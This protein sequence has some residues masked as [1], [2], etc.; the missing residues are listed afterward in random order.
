MRFALRQL[1]K[2][3]SFT[4]IAVLTLA[5]GIGACVSIFSVANAMLLRHQ[6]YQDPGRLVWVW[7][8]NLPDSGSWLAVSAPNFVDWQ[9]QASAFEQL[10]AFYQR[11]PD[12]ERTE[13]DAAPAERVGVGRVTVNLLSMLGVKPLMGR[14]FL[15]EDEKNQVVVLSHALWQRRFN[16]DPNMLDRTVRLNG[17]D[18][19]VIGIMP[20]EFHFPPEP[21]PDVLWVPLAL[22]GE[23]LAEA[24]RGLRDWCVLGRLRPGA[25][26][27][28]AQAELDTIMDRPAR[29]HPATNAKQG[30]TLRP[31]KIFWHHPFERIIY[32]LIGAVGMLVLMACFN[33]ANLLLAKATARQH[34]IALR[35]ALGATPLQI[36][37]Q[38]LVE[39]LLL[40]LLGGAA[41]LLLAFWGTKLL[42]VTIP[43]HNYRVGEIAIDATVL[44]F[45]LLL[46]LFTGLAFGLAPALAAAKVDLLATLKEGGRQ[47]E[48][49]RP[50]R[51]RNG[52]VV[53]QVALA[54]VL[55][56]GALITVQKFFEMRR[57]KWGFDPERLLTFR[58][59]LPEFRYSND[60]AF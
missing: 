29:E 32:V 11:A 44:G 3:P 5:L 13:A 15:P 33:V 53:A 50:Q 40:S 52:L 19:G 36:M 9:Q 56:T 35:A 51:L 18:Y 27:K 6:R 4:A 28:S 30:A 48:G 58:L 2:N 45:A 38:L 39:S 26:M 16:A 59:P 37:R 60:L 8:R 17:K 23:Q 57:A 24:K 7:Q 31:L 22:D 21:E 46:S 43:I 55:L 54:V 47:G 25:T 41:G 10:A 14:T 34:E 1:L 12:L 20:P 42:A 49:K